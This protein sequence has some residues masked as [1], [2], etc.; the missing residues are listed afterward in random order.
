MRR[1][2]LLSDGFPRIVVALDLNRTV[3]QTGLLKQCIA[4]G[5]QYSSVTYDLHLH[6]HPYNRFCSGFTRLIVVD[7]ET[8]QAGFVWQGTAGIF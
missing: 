2:I 8:L 3:L 4:H 5:V 1:R 6:R 7:R